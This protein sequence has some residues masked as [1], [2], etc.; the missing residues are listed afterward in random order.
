M[1]E[2]ARRSLL[3]AGAAAALPVRAQ[4]RVFTLG[5]VTQAAADRPAGA[6]GKPFCST[7][8]A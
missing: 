8:G 7:C 5:L 6:S 4:Q 3:V 2:I 1:T